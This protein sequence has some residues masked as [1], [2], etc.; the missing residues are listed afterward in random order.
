MSCKI[1]QGVLGGLFSSSPTTPVRH[2]PSKS[3]EVPE[4][5]VGFLALLVPLLLSSASYPSLQSMH[6][7]TVGAN[8]EKPMSSNYPKEGSKDRMP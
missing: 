7:G 5:R 8:P 1:P 6:K 4:G 3:E 2:S